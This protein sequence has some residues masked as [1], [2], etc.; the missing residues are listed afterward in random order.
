MGEREVGRVACIG[1]I[2]LRPLHLF[3]GRRFGG[4]VSPALIAIT[5]R[6]TAGTDGILLRLLVAATGL[7]RTGIARLS[8]LSSRWVAWFVTGFFSGLPTRLCLV[9]GHLRLAVAAGCVL[10]LSG[11]SRL[12]PVTLRRPRF[13]LSILAG[14]G[15]VRFLC[16]RI[17]LSSVL[18]LTAPVA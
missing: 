2:L 3:A 10:P 13:S 12:L 9:G 16:D 7:R 18:T 6:R 4:V 1:L 5:P 8:E 14:S 17:A 11:G 15:S